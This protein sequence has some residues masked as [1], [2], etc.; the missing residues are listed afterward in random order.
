[1][2]CCYRLSRAWR[3]GLHVRSAIRRGMRS[4]E[5]PL[6]FKTK[7][8]DFSEIIDE[9][10]ELPRPMIYN[11]EG[12]LNIPSALAINDLIVWTTPRRPSKRP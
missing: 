8:D 1:R 5:L 7:V 2:C 11:V 4:L 9:H 3:P 12:Y 10:L 6:N